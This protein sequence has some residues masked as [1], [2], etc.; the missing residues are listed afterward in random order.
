MA[1]YSGKQDS[2][3]HQ[4]R[5]NQYILMPHYVNFQHGTLNIVHFMYHLACGWKK[6]LIDFQVVFPTYKPVVLLYHIY[7]CSK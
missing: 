2:K 4:I 6:A 1:W 5:I 7:Y 3:G